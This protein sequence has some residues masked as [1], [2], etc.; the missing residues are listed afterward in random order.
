MTDILRDHGL[1][2]PIAADEYQIASFREKVQ[3]EGAIDDIPF[4]VTYGSGGYGY[5][6]NSVAVADVNGD[7]KPDVIVA[8]Y[9]SSPPVLQ[10]VRWAC[11]WATETELSRE[12]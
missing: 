7:G 4:N 12:P 6:I 11:C 2:E 3:G 5:G 8:N 9:C 10:M 1:A